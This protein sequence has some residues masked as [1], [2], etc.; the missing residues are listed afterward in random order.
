MKK[1]ILAK[2]TDDDGDK[3]RKAERNYNTFLTL[4]ENEFLSNEQK[5]TVIQRLPV[6]RQEVISLYEKTISKY[7]VAH[8]IQA[9]YRLSVNNELFVETY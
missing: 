9:Q 8:V 2:I 5:Q 4:M 3:I 6:L 1:V 7:N